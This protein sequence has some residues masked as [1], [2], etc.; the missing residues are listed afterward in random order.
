MYHSTFPGNCTVLVH[1]SLSFTYTLYFFLHAV[2]YLAVLNM[3]M[4]G[5][6]NGDSEFR[7]S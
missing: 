7:E 3:Y 5:W 6:E 2:F 4:N 1:T